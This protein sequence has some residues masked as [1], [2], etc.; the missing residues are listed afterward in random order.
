MVLWGNALV[1]FV[2]KNRSSS[3]NAT[4]SPSERRHAEVSCEKQFMPSMFIWTDLWSKP[5]M[6]LYLTCY[7]LCS[8]VSSLQFAEPNPSS[9]DRTSEPAISYSLSQ[10][11]RASFDEY[12]SLI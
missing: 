11:E 7:P 10:Q 12:L 2:L 4:G 1:C 5:R 9:K 8:S 6:A 3:A